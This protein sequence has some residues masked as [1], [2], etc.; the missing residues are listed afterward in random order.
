M[1]LL[2]VLAALAGGT[3]YSGWGPAAIVLF[4]AIHGVWR[5]WVAVGG[6]ALLAAVLVAWFTLVIVIWSM[7]SG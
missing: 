1:A 2:L 3:A 6:A 5:R 4:L 7:V